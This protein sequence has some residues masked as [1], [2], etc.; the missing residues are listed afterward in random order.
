VSGINHRP[1]AKI[2]RLAMRHEGANWTAYYAMPNTMADA[3]YLGSIRMAAVVDNPER[4]QAFMGMM[5]DLVSDII[6][7]S[8]G[9]RPTFPDGPQ[10]APESEKAGHA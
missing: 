4:K 7:E 8:T 3:V 1:A 6:E 10:A 9:Q 5:R 2:G